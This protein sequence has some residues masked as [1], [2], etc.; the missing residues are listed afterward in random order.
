M[1]GVNYAKSNIPSLFAKPKYYEHPISK[2]YKVA[3]KLLLNTNKCITKI[4][5]FSRKGGS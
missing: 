2:T 1:V 5:A 4:Q 3:H